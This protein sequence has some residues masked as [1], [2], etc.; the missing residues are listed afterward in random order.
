MTAT[1]N[2]PERLRYFRRR[3]YEYTLLAAHLVDGESGAALYRQTKT[4]LPTPQF[5]EVVKLRWRK[6]STK[7]IDGKEV[8]FAG[9]FRL[10]TS[11]EWGTYGW[12]FRTYA[13][14]NARYKALCDDIDA[15]RNDS[16]TS[17]MPPAAEGVN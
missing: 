11:E 9:G 6:P 8:E 14:A 1:G 13:Q 4:G 2:V 12:T 3:P 16:G 17:E 7:V 10:P 15:S 5:F